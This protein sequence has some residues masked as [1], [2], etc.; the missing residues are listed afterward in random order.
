[1]TDATQLRALLE[2][3]GFS[4]RG[5]ARHLDIDERTMRRYAAGELPVP[6]VVTMAL[7]KKIEAS[8]IIDALGMI[9]KLIEEYRDCPNQG[10]LKDNRCNAALELIEG[11]QRLAAGEEGVLLARP[12]MF[13]REVR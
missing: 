8:Q 6:K 13:Q 7:Q 3:A 1:M 12:D 5:A 2:G 9:E 4:Q 10:L 11:I